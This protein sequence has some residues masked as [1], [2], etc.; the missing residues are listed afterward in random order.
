V[1]FIQAPFSNAVMILDQRNASLVV[2]SCAPLWDASLH[3]WP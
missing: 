3:S 1:P 2:C